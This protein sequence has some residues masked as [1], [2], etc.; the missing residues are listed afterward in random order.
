MPTAEARLA[1]ARASRYLTQLCRHLG[2][3]NRM[4]HRPP[5]GHGEAHI[6]PAVRQVECTDTH[7]TVRFADGLWTLEATADALTVRVDAGDEEA[8]RRLQVQITARIEK[9]GRREGLQVDWQ[10]VRCDPRP[11]S[12]RDAGRGTPGAGQGHRTPKTTWALAAGGALVVALHLGWGG[13]ALAGATWTGWTANAVLALALGKLLLLGGHFVLR[14]SA[15]RRGTAPR[16]RPRQRERP[17]ADAT[18]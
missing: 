2:Q 18:G 16:H 5:L 8:L 12:E 10:P 11:Q 6:M 4:G 14:R 7:G 15:A 13:A 3:M 9:I 17:D 1:T